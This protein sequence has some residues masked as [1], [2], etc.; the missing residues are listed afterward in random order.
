MGLTAANLFSR[1]RQTIFFTRIAISENK[2][3]IGRRTPRKSSNPVP[4]AT[5]NLAC[6]DIAGFGT[7]FI[8]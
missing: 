6:F 8:T 7:I 2:P 4:A 3:L 5:G 1:Y